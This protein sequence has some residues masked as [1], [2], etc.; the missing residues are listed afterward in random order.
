[1]EGEKND[2]RAEISRIFTSKMEDSKPD[3]LEETTFELPEGLK[4]RAVAKT[5]PDF[6]DGEQ[7]LKT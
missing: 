4:V 5:V 6:G 2:E 1:M 3:F 7:E